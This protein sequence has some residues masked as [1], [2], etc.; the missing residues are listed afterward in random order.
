MPEIF[1]REGVG[2]D[3]LEFVPAQEQSVEP[4]QL[5]DVIRFEDRDVVVPE[6]DVLQFGEHVRERVWN[7][8]DTATPAIQMR[9]QAN[10]HKNNT[11]TKCL[12]ETKSLK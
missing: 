10:Q 9:Y 11:E 7:C 6:V 12:K 4:V 5:F 8:V 2:L 3:C 1:A